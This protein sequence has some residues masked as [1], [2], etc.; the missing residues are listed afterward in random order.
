M[1]AIIDGDILRY[2]IGF[3]AETGW[4][5][6]TG[7]E[8]ATPPFDYVRDMLN[9]RIGYIKGVARAQY[10]TLYIT[11]GKT[12]RED[13]ATVKPYKGTRPSNKP[14]HYDNLTVY[15][16]DIL[17]AKV[18]TEIEADDAMAIDHVQSA[19]DTTLCSR[20]KDL[21]QVPG[22]ILSWE[23]GKQPEFYQTVERLGDLHKL[24]SGKVHGWGY[25]FFAYQLL[26]GDTVDNIPGLPG[27]GEKKALPLIWDALQKCVDMGPT[28]SDLD[29]CKAI[30]WAVFQAYEDKY[31]VEAEERMTEQAQ[32]LWMTRRLN[33]DGSPELWRKGLYV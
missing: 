1:R 33:P 10:S 8:D 4:R 13:I 6:I 12:F 24:D 29:I 20:D 9:Q 32:L 5:H 7:D 26:I 3:A 27:M 2:E 17:N 15:M 19:D 28:A 21:R 14:W 22:K 30:E 18:V 25:M 16:R 23:L 11:E 31:D